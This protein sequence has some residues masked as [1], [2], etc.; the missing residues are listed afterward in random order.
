[1]T[2]SVLEVARDLIARGEHRRASDI[3]RVLALGS[4]HDPDIWNTLAACHDADDRPDI[5]ETLRALGRVL[6]N[7]PPSAR[8]K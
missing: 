1:M 8:S 6:Q 2:S 5:G 3:L 7:F 4:P